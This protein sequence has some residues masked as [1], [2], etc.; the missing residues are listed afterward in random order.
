MV[1]V[2][3]GAFAVV[4]LLIAAFYAGDIVW[5]ER[6][7][8]LHEV[9]DAMPVPTWLQWTAKFTSLLLVILSTIVL[10][11]LTTIAVQAIDGYYHFELALYAKSIGVPRL[12][13]I[14]SVVYDNQT[15]EATVTRRADGKYVVKLTVA[16]AK[17]LSDGLG[18]PKPV[19][20][21]DPVRIAVLGEGGKELFTEK[22]RITGPVETLEIVVGGKPVRAG[23]DPFHEL[24]DAHPGDNA[25]SL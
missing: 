9:S 21:D 18:E 15:R 14:R 16:S 4:A 11:V 10:A 22:R 25:R 7:L 5:R 17:L 13:G 24:I 23:I 1:D 2:I 6:T 20:N 8:H 12:R 19:P 3:R